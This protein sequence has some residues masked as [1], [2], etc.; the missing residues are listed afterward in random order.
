LAIRFGKTLVIQELDFIEPILV[1]YLRKDFRHQGPRWVVLVGDKFIDYSEGFRLFLCTRN[2][3]IEIQPAR[4]ALL[5]IINFTV[6]RSGLESKL[7]SII[8]NHEKPELEEKNQ[9]LSQQEE[10]L[11][12]QLETLQK[13]LLEEL[14]NSQGSI[15]ENKTLIESLNQTKLKSIKIQ[16]SLEESAQLQHDIEEKR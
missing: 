16:A 11:K 8:I 10:S 6:T 5:A 15:L 14:A 12:I 13:M 4:R 9:Q 3:G 1:P 2:S 7:L